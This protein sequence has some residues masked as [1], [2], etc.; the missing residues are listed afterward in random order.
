MLRILNQKLSDTGTFKKILLLFGMVLTLTVAVGTTFSYIT[1]NTPTIRNL[2]VNGLDPDGNLIIQKVV[3]HPFG[4]NYQVPD[5]LNFTFEVCLGEDYANATVKTTEGEKDADENG[6]IT[7]T[8]L[9]DSRATV[10][11]IK[12]ETNVTVTE[13]NIGK[14]FNPD[15]KDKTITVQKHQDNILKFTNTYQPE[16]ANTA[17]LTVTG[18]KTLEGREWQVGDNF[19]FELEVFENSVWNSLGTQTVTYEMVE[20]ADPEN[21]GQTVLV[22]KPGFDE[23]DFSGMI[24]DYDFNKAGTY[25]FRIK[26]LNDTNAGIVYD[27]PE[28]NFEVLVGDADMNGSLEIQSVQSGSKNTT[29]T[30]NT[31]VN[32]VFV[33]RYAPVGSAEV[34]INIQKK[35]EDTSG[36]NRLPSGFTFELYS[37]ENELVKTSE[38]TDPSGETSIRLVYAPEDAGKTFTYVLK[39]TNAG[40]TLG[41]LTYDNTEYKIQVSVVDNQD[42][43][44]SAFVDDWEEPVESVQDNTITETVVMTEPEN[45]TPEETTP[46]E[47][48]AEEEIIPVIETPVEEENPAESEQISTEIEEE[49]HEEPQE[50][51]QEIA[52][53]EL[54][55]QEPGDPVEREIVPV[56]SSG[57]GTSTY[58]AAFTNKYDPEDASVTLTGTKTLSG[59]KL[60][61]EEFTFRLYTT[62]ERF[63]ISEETSLVDTASNDEEGSFGFDPL[64]FNQVGTYYYVMD[65]DSSGAVR[66]ITYDESSYLITITVTDQDGKLAAETK[67]TDAYG[68]SV[69]GGICFKNSYKANAITL[70][71]SGKKE[72]VGKELKAGEFYFQLYDANEQYAAQGTPLQTV[73]NNA[74]G[75]FS[76]R[77]LKFEKEGTYHYVV[78]EDASAEK[79]GMQYDDTVYGISVTVSDPGDGQLSIDNVSMSSEGKSVDELVFRNIY[80]APIEPGVPDEP[81]NP[82]VPDESKDIEPEDTEKED[83]TQDKPASTA[84]T[85]D[86]LC[87]IVLVIFA[88]LMLILFNVI[89]RKKENLHE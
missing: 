80:N 21:P 78:K 29:I 22:A 84:D 39:E 64:N 69:T 28:S 70:P 74:N 79:E 89:R 85:N 51:P 45:E 9:A 77:E 57:T 62:N 52:T 40:Q 32:I 87:Y 50:E 4:E 16:K 26:E 46:D 61:D 86:M 31:K 65:E 12:D 43:T 36:Q 2:F 72:L 88:G 17:A 8:V 27:I 75:E 23:F 11:D 25:S 33:N 3:K 42:G 41:A 44:V 49:E 59:R 18:R 66:G 5:D 20:Q 24:R 15:S 48:V 35:L 55:P 73:N 30:E 68:V 58:T 1:T 19:T 10:Y 13:K 76:F 14:G 63:E 67:I 81:E 54:E 71:L 56:S 82:T 53:E 7:M 37:E 34:S 38:P 6:K 83:V 47:I 60:R